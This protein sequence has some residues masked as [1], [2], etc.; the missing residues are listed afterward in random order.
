MSWSV[1]LE[2][3]DTR[4]PMEVDRPEGGTMGAWMSVTYNYSPFYRE[5][6]DAE[7]SLWWLHG[8]TGMEAIPHLERAVAALGTDRT[9]SYWDAT[10]GNAGYALSILLKWAERHPCAVFRVL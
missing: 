9:E 10:P 2:H 6:L 1:S 3:P 8:K 7:R 5:Y 4:E